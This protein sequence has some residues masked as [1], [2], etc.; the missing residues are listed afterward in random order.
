MLRTLAQVLAVVGGVVLFAFAAS[1]A[2]AYH[3]QQDG[4]VVRTGFTADSPVMAAV[5]VAS[6]YASVALM[7]LG[8]IALSV[9]AL[10]DTRRS[11]FQI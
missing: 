9:L 4:L 3:A 5:P 1:T 11:D 8:G 2:N 7:V 10:L 6:Y